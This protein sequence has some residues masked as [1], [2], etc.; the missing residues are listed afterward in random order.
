MLPRRDFHQAPF[1]RVDSFS[2]RLDDGTT[3]DLR[4]VHGADAAVVS[5]PPTPRG[6]E[7]PRFPRS[8]PP[9]LGNFSPTDPPIAVQSFTRDVCF[10]R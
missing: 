9:T 4:E 5:H 2:D 6:A 3:C 8:H 10:A 1:A 7:T